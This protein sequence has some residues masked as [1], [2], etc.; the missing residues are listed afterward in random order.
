MPG[1]LSCPHIL[2]HSP[3]VSWLQGALVLLTPHHSRIEE[4]GDPETL[5]GQCSSRGTPVSGC[6]MG[7][8]GSCDLNWALG[9]PRHLPIM[10]N[11]TRKSCRRILLEDMSPGLVSRPIAMWAIAS[12][13]ACLPGPVR[14]CS[15][16]ALG[17][18]SW[19]LMRNLHEY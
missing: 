18:P 11:E 8:W 2:S 12:F 15:L 7:R 10:V 9:F 14:T 5:P 1:R 16:C 17:A 4:G 13:P 3:S 6:V 19:S